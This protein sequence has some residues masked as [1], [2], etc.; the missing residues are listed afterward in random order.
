MAGATGYNVY[1]RTAAG[2]YDFSDPVNGGTPVTGTTLT[3]AGSGLASDTTYHYVVR[4]V[5]GTPA[6]ESADSNELSAATISRPAAPTG[7]GATAV[8]AGAIDV[9]WTSVV[10]A[11]GYNVYRRTA[12]GSYDF[13]SPRNGA[14]PL[15]GTTYRDASAT[16]ATTYRYTVRAVETGAGAAQV[17]SLDGT[18]SAAVTS[19]ATAP[20]APSA[21]SVTSGGNVTSATMCSIAAGTRYVNNAGKSAVGVSATV[22]APEPGASVVFRATTPNSAVVTA[23]VAAAATTTTTL[24][25]SGLLDGTITLT[26]RSRDAAGNLSG[27]VGPTNVVVKD[28]AAPPL[29]ASYSGG[30]LGLSPTV[31]GSSQCGATVRATKTGGG[32]EGAVFSTQITSGSSYSIAVEGPLLGLGSVS[33]SV[34]AEDPAGNTSAAVTTGN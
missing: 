23:T 13:S 9:S 8:A 2:S 18:E 28:T 20:A 15:T 17:E 34:T 16:D 1:R 10:G 7:V 19:D 12:A 26:A 11:T 27:T 31:S 22:A 21:T 14:T 32:N 5:A 6:T 30:A 29:T 25:L 24:D 33:Y 3:D 4:T